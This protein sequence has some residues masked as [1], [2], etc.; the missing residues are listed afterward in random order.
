MMRI[1]LPWALFLIAPFM[2]LPTSLIL[3]PVIQSGPASYPTSVTR[4]LPIVPPVVKVAADDDN[5]VV[6]DD[7]LVGK[8]RK[9]ID[10]GVSFLRSQQRKSDGSWEVGPLN[11]G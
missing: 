2:L 5:I 1:W 7:E 4:T 6:G 11:A 3:P 8:V 9:S 10:E